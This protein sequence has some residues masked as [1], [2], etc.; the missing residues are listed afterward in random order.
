MASASTL[1]SSARSPWKTEPWAL[2]DALPALAAALVLLSALLAWSVAQGLIDARYVP[3]PQI[4]G[5]T[6]Q[7][8]GRVTLGMLYPNGIAALAVWLGR[9]GSIPAWW[10][11]VPD[12]LAAAA[13]IAVL[14]H[15][16]AA[17]LG[18]RW[19]WG[20]A[21]L[22]LLQPLF[23]G[24][25]LSGNGEA[26]MLLALYAVGRGASRVRRAA[27]VV[28]YLVLASWMLML[29]MADVRAWVVVV[30][31]AVCLFPCVPRGLLAR[32]PLTYHLAVFLPVVFTVLAL[33]YTCWWW[34]GDTLAWLRDT[35]AGGRGLL[36]PTEVFRAQGR[37]LVWG[38]GGIV[39][40]ALLALSGKGAPQ[41]W[42]ATYALAAAV[43]CAVIVVAFA[44]GAW[45][46][47]YAVLLL[48]PAALAA[49]QCL[50]AQRG[51]LIG[52]LSLGALSG[53]PEVF[54]LVTG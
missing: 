2:R 8:A 15:D 32:A 52:V 43:L 29:F 9:I 14:W 12:L 35:W 13:T 25:A 33:L 26:V 38:A 1:P 5:A 44:R 10:P 18:R 46:G 45:P 54:A 23:V 19:A 21:M 7:A 40:V 49:G 28:G 41:A 20:L 36:V 31:L 48:A 39:V 17:Q 51:W 42:R 22:F 34:N 24:A 3:G 47:D 30:A 6:A 11:I 50:P 37:P 4:A 16:L 53:A 27:D